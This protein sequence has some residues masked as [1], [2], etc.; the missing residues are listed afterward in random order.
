MSS[1]KDSD[2]LRISNGSSSRSSVSQHDDKDGGSEFKITF[3]VSNLAKSTVE[4]PVEDLFYRHGKV[5][6]L[7][8][9][10]GV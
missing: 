5:H 9:N 1:A 4:R 6:S 2:S 10:F 3:F 7:L 8:H